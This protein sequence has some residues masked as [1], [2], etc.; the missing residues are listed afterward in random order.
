VRMIRPLLLMRKSFVFLSKKGSHWVFWAENG[1]GY[2]RESLC[3]DKINL[4]EYF[5]LTKNNLIKYYELHLNCAF[6]MGLT[7]IFV[8]PWQEY[9]W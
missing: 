1:E 4:K 9:T 2:R 7:L 8:E 6:A 5:F 3:F